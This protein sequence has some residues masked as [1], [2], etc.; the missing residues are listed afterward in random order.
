[1]VTVS[2]SSGPSSNAYTSR[3]TPDSAAKSQR[4]NRNAAI[5]SRSNVH[6]DIVATFIH[7][8]LAQ[9]FFKRK[10]PEVVAVRHRHAVCAG[11]GDQDHIAFRGVGR[12]F[13]LLR[14]YVAALADRA[15]DIEQ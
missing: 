12:Q 6:S 7:I 8:V 14:Q 15:D 13:P 4:T 2:T 5:A 11:V 10:L 9:Q 3:A 1:M